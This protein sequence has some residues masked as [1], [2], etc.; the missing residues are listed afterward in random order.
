VIS[1]YLVG[2]DVVLGW[3]RATPDTVASELGRT[4]TRL[5]IDL[6]LR[7][8]E[9]QVTGQPY[10]GRPGLPQRRFD[11]E[12]EEGSD[13]IAARVIRSSGAK[14]GPRPDVKANLRRV[15]EAFRPAIARR[16]IVKRP[17]PQRTELSQSSFLRSVL[18][19]MN[20]EIRDEIRGGLLEAF[21][22]R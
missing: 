8:E 7:V 2:D 9:A 3:L 4:L 17:Q 15:K 6:Q 11:L 10:A 22:R 14:S 21:T 12:I 16:T 13:R 1:A 20:P 18:E 5:G 19:E